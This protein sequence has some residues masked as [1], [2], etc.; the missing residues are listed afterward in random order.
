MALKYDRHI[1]SGKMETHYGKDRLHAFVCVNQHTTFS[2]RN[3]VRCPICNGEIT[4]QL[5]GLRGRPR[6]TPKEG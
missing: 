6:K 2:A 5:T 4:E 3:M 1:R